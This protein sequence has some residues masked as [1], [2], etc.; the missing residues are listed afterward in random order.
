VR[1]DAVYRALEAE[2]AAAAGRHPGAPVTVLDVGGG[3][4]VWAVPLAVAGCAVTVIDP[5]PDALAVL[6]RRATEAGCA[7]RITG[8]QGDTENLPEP[9]PPADLVL[10]HGVLE[11]VDDPGAAVAALAASVTPGGALSVL[12]ANRFAAVLARAM[13]GR[14][15]DA[16]R[17]LDPDGD[18]DGGE[19]NADGPGR[20]RRLDTQKLQFLLESAG[21][22]VELLQGDGVVT[23]LVPGAM[24]DATPGAAELLAELELRAARTP[25]LRDVASRLHAIARRPLR[26]LTSR[27]T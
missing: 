3:S 15:T 22:S 16:L 24:L 4:G 27:A 25:P 18:S 21:L 11:V 8:V 19:R 10:A 2:V 1:G 26:E 14:L 20:G 7:E 17:L 9:D 12:V 23:D 5:S 6:H 13:A